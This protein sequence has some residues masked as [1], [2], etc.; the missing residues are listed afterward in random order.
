MLDRFATE[1]VLHSTM[2]RLRGKYSVLSVMEKIQKNPNI[3]KIDRYKKRTEELS[4]LMDKMFDLTIDKKKLAIKFYSKE[5]RS[6][7]EQSSR[8][9]IHVGGPTPL[10]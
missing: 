2:T 1:E 3:T 9:K 4:L 7:N 10:V 5:L 6:L 8:E